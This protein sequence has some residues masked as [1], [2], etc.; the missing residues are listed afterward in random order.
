MKAITLTQPWASLVAV[1]AKT[2]ETRS[3]RTS[4]RGPLAIHAAKGFPPSA[5]DFAECPL[6]QSYVGQD[7]LP[8]GCILATCRL[9]ACNRIVAAPPG[10][11]SLFGNYEPGRFAW[12]LE[13]VTPLPDIDPCRGA[14]SLWEWNDDAYWQRREDW[15][16]NGD[17]TTP[18]F[19]IRKDNA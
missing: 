16:P 9:V 15:G 4:Y 7:P 5:R 11:E 6:V 1:G 12:L 18:G 19:F 3:W 2:I 17:A 13:D 8:T 14:L 10:D